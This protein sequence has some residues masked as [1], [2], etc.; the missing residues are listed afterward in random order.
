MRHGIVTAT[1]VL[2]AWLLALPGTGSAELYKW[3]DDKGRVHYSDSIPPEEMGKRRE[4][5]V[6]SERGMTIDRIE[7]PPTREELRERAEAKARAAAEARKEA[8]QREHDRILLQTFESVAAMKRAR[9]ERIAAIDGQIKIARDRVES[10]TKRHERLVER[11]AA[12]E[13]NGRG[14]AKK[15]YG[16]IESIEEQVRSQRA[17]IGRQRREQAEIRARFGR[18]IERFRELKNKAAE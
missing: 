6:K 14:N 15:V 13:R 1:V 18:D 10:L 12:M 7:P 4:R 17:F 11:A 8:E 16:E 2:T 3:V 9:D 5:E